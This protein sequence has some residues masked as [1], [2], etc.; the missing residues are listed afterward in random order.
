MPQL[1]LLKNVKKIMDLSL[2]QDQDQKLMGS[3]LGWEPS[4]SQV[5]WK[6]V[7]LFLCNPADNPTNLQTDWN[8]NITSLAKEIT[9]KAF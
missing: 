9:S 5:S 3:I 4:S 7:E 8:E 1:A 2:Y 6:T